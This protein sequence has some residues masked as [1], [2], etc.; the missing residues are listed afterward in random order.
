MLWL[1]YKRQFETL[2]TNLPLAFLIHLSHHSIQLSGWLVHEQ[3]ARAQTR[4]ASCVHRQGPHHVYTDKARIMCTQTRPASCVHRCS[5]CLYIYTH[6]SA[7]SQVFLYLNNSLT[8]LSKMASPNNQSSIPT[9]WRSLC[10]LISNLNILP[11][12]VSR[13]IICWIN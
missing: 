3:C 6:Y 4:P 7:T 9:K 2:A 10:Q 12:D 1:P 13:K 5:T 11:T 8:C